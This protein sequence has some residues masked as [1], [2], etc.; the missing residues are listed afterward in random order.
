MITGA[1]CRLPS[2]GSWSRRLDPA[3]FFKL[4]ADSCARSSAPD[5]F[6]YDLTVEL[7]GG[8]THTVTSTSGNQTTAELNA[9][10]P[11]LGT[12]LEWIKHEAEAIWQA[13]LAHR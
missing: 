11:G 10:L 6:Q 7:P 3:K 4:H 8:K 12:L 1:P 9:I 5:Q 13:K 2:W